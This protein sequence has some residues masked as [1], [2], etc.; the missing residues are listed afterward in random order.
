LDDDL[1]GNSSTSAQRALDSR[2]DAEVGAHLNEL[3]LRLAQGMDKTLAIKTISI[4]SVSDTGELD[5][6][7]A[8]RM[9]VALQT[10][11]VHTYALKILDFS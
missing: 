10:P 9:G 1:K 6:F 7:F 11:A 2:E 4:V 5:N 3:I 8:Q